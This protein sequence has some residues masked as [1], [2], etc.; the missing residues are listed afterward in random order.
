MPK[1]SMMTA[2]ERTQLLAQ[3]IPFLHHRTYGGAIWAGVRVTDN[4]YGTEENVPSYRLL[5][6]LEY[7]GIYKDAVNIT[8]AD[9]IALFSE[10]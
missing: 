2:D 9:Q 10:E 7:D 1:H 8:I 3:P 4:F 5:K 6:N